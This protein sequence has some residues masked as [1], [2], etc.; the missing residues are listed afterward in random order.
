MKYLNCIYVW[1]YDKINRILG[2][3]FFYVKY[4]SKFKEKFYQIKNDITGLNKQ[5]PKT[6][7]ELLMDERDKHTTFDW[8]EIFKRKILKITLSKLSIKSKIYRSKSKSKMA[9]LRKVG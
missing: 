8:K 5:S 7:N 6:K 2:D 1:Q 4:N 9:Y 3:N